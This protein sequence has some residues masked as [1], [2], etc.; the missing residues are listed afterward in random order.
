MYMR[1]GNDAKP[2]GG[3]GLFLCLTVAFLIGHVSQGGAA[4]REKDVVHIESDR[5]E[6][7]EQERQVVFQGHVVATQGDLTIEGDRLTVFYQEEDPGTV[8]NGSLARR[9]DRIVIEGHVRISQRNCL[10]TG[11]RAVYSR[12][13][14]KVV[15]TGEPRVQ[16]D[17]DVI[18]GTSITLF[19]DSE[20]SII[21]GAPNQPVEATIFNPG[22]KGLPDTGSVETAPSSG[23]DRDEG[24]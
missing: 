21:E 19:L 9:V 7:E 15:L 14:N 4:P 3:I 13:D 22:R 8:E 2:G 6:A 5:L 23:A 1:T 16:R 24:V 11:E 12:S 10:A 17:K 18:Q 20:K